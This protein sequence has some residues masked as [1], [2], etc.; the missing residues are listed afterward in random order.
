MELDGITKKPDLASIVAK[1]ADLVAQQ[2]IDIPRILVVPKGE[3]KSGFR[4]FT[5]DL[6]RMRYEAPNVTLWAAYLRTGQVDRIGVGAGTI[7]EQR[8]EDYVV[9]G[10]IDFDDVAYDEHADLLYDLAEQV[11]RHFLLYLSE[12][13]ARKVLRLHQKEIA[14]FVHVQMQKHFWQDTQVAYDVVITR[15]FTE[16]RNSAYTAAADEPPLDFRISTP[17]NSN[18]S[19]Y[20]FGGFSRCLYP[21]QKFQSDAERKLAVILERDAFR[22]VH[23]LRL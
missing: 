23:I 14:S 19:R 2:T 18:M 17:D 1:T 15:G 4:P 11:T 16:L 12:D 6:S 9:S 13:D 8:L 7:D 22:F 3:V 5:L 20:L 10:L 21:T